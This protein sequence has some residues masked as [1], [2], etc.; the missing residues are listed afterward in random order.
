MI[1][2]SIYTTILLSLLNGIHGYVEV[3]A[4][5]NAC[6]SATSRTASNVFNAP[7]PGIISGIRI[8][9]NS[10][11]VKCTV[12]SVP[13][14]FG[15]NQAGMWE[16]IAMIL[17]RVTDETNKYGEEYY[18]VNSQT[19]GLS[20]WRHWNTHFPSTCYEPTVPGA[21]TFLY[22]M[23]NYNWDSNELILLNP[24]YSVTTNDKFML[25]YSEGYV[26]CAGDNTGTGCSTVYF[27]YQTN[28]PTMFPTQPPTHKNCE[29][30]GE[31][32]QINWYKLQNAN[33]NS[34]QIPYHNFS[35][36]LDNSK[37]EMT[38]DID[39]EYI[40]LSSDG[41]FDLEYNLGTTYVVGFDS[42]STN[43]NKIN[44]PG[45]CENRIFTSFMSGTFDQWWDYSE[46][47]Y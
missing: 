43:L 45:N 35:I 32:K 20:E 23:N 46:Y 40:G 28:P 19:T 26:Q 36:I 24:Q 2:Y 15:C 25:Q 4:S 42:F 13:T 21:K 33:D 16:F 7:Q 34:L 8:V 14:N 11:S 30:E 6:Y 5:S 29:S 17:F 12:G 1:G 3:L 38:F 31:I 47:P 37:L 39:L 10:G 27:L 9:H 18:P 22:N 41:N 44:E